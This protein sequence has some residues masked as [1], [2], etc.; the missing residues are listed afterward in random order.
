MNRFS[1]CAV[2]VLSS[3]VAVMPLFVGR[4]TSSEI[5][6]RAS[7]RIQMAHRASGRI[8]MAHRASGRIEVA[9]RAS[10]RMTF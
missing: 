7:G 4:M 9:H 8:E 3:A 1:F 5:A 2:A 10:G 6:Y